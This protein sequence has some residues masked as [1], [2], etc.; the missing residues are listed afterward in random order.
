MTRS[1]AHWQQPASD[2]ASAAQEAKQLKLGK[3]SFE[4][5]AD[6]DWVRAAKEN[7]GQGFSNNAVAVLVGGDDNPAALPTRQ[8]PEHRYQVTHSG[9]GTGA[10]RAEIQ[11]RLASKRK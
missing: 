4:K 1:P 5:P 11:N 10:A 3:P 6:M 2:K 7:L 8:I 9:T